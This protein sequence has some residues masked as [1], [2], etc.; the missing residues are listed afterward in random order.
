MQARRTQ[1]RRGLRHY[2][3]RYST[4]AGI[5]K[6]SNREETRSPTAKAKGSGSLRFEGLGPV[7]FEGSH[8]GS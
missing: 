2:A 6:Q 7:P 5:G 4:A 1:K 3:R 8:C